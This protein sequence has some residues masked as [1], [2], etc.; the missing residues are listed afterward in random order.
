MK[1]LAYLLLLIAVLQTITGCAILPF[2]GEKGAAGT[3]RCRQNCKRDIR[4]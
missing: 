1:T 4:D 2:G 3:G